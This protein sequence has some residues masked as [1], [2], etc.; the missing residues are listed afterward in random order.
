MQPRQ[1]HP[2]NPAP[3]TIPDRD[4]LQID[5]MVETLHQRGIIGK[6]K[7]FLSLVNKIPLVAARMMTTLITGE[8]GTGKDVMARALHYLGPRT[9]GPFVPVHCG[10]LSAELMENELFGHVRGSFTG[11][12][13]STKGLVESAR[14]G[15]LFLDDID[16]LPSSSQ[17]KLLQLLQE[18]EYRQLGSS[19]LER[20][21]IWIISA[22]NADLKGKM[23]NGEFRADLYYRLAGMTLRIPTLRERRED[24]PLLI[25][26]F[27]QQESDAIGA[28]KKRICCELLARMVACDWPGNIRELKSCIESSATLC[29]GEV[30][31]RLV[32]EDE[33]PTADAMLGSPFP[34]IESTVL[35]TVK[36]DLVRRAIKQANGNLQA[37]SRILKINRSTLY[38]LRKKYS[39]D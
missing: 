31:T 3:R 22:T 15:V 21:D 2:P 1:T 24:I 32:G 16:L 29:K 9:G 18:G 36:T 35:D 4:H 5:E 10:P 38:R 13:S 30:I 20:S 6:S 11:A 7:A 14:G 12:V 8:T 23:E 26:H 17:G 34:E 25:E 33:L 39:I 28:N 19:E 37:A 27:L